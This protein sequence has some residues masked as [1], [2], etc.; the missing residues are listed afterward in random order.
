MMMVDAFD[1]SQREGVAHLSPRAAQSH[2]EVERLLHLIA[3]LIVVGL[4]GVEPVAVHA[5]RDDVLVVGL[6]VVV[7]GL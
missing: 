5:L 6:P 7:A 2:Y 4:A 3:S 1:M